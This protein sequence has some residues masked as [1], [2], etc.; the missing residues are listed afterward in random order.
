M[1]A[2]SPKPFSQQGRYIYNLDDGLTTQN[3]AP[4]STPGIKRKQRYF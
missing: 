4:G 3:P 1:L 2:L